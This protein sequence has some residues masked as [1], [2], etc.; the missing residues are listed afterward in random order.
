MARLRLTFT[1]I[2]ERGDRVASVVGLSQTR[3]VDTL[4]N[5]SGAVSN[6]DPRK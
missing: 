1:P 4:L 5:D 3:D 2:V 6:Y